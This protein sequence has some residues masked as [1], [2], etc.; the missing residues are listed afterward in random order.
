MR[1]QPVERKASVFGETNDGL[2]VVGAPLGR[3][4]QS[5]LAHEGGRKGESEGT[6]I[7]AGENDLAAWR[8]TRD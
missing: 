5:R 8:E 7:K 6:L 4:P 1:D 3:D 2:E